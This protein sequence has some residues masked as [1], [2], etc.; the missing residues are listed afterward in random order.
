MT[1]KSDDAAAR[2]ESAQARRNEPA[3]G[4]ARLLQ[5]SL[6][7]PILVVLHVVLCLVGLW[8]F[9]VFALSPD[10]MDHATV[11]RNLAE[12]QGYRLD[13]IPFHP[14]VLPAVSHLPE[15]HGLMKP[16]EIAPLFWLFGSD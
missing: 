8:S 14:G 13:L 12:G 15:W 1:S 7:V 6:L 10:E 16:F 3:R 5:P 4:L 2:R 9:G 11:A